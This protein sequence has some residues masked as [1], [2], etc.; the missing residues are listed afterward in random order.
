[1]NFRLKSKRQNFK[2]S[3]EGVERINPSTQKKK[4]DKEKVW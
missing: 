4:K 1:M 2:A 3:G